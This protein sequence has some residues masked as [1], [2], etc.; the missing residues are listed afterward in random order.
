MSDDLIKR[1]LAL[2]E[3]LVEVEPGKRV[4]IRRPAEAQVPAFAAATPIERVR[5]NVVG[6][7][8][9]T[10]ADILGPA[11]GGDAEVSFDAALWGEIVSDRIVWL[12][13]VHEALIEAINA[14]G[15]QGEAAAKN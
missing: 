5:D 3:S 9:I 8:G 13:I 11:L 7:E 2:R 12:K 1:L 15:V 6:W 4:R 10:E 14:H